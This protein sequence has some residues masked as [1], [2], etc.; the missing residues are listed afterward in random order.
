MVSTTVTLPARDS[1]SSVRRSAKTSAGPTLTV[2]FRVA[3]SPAFRVSSAGVTESSPALRSVTDSFR[4]CGASARVVDVQGAREL[5]AGVEVGD[6]QVEGGGDGQLT[7]GDLPRS[8]R[9][10]ALRPAAVSV[11][12]AFSAP[13]AFA[14]ISAVPVNE[15]SLAFSSSPLPS[16]V[17]VSGSGSKPSPVSSL[18]TRSPS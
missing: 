11:A 16:S 2:T 3:D 15:P 9:V 1:P 13:W 14:G 6:G 8:L 5:G 12:L 18:R 10:S 4:V 17:R 7:G